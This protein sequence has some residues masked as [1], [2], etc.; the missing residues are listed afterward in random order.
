M[1]QFHWPGFDST[2]KLSAEEAVE[3]AARIAELSKAGLPLGPG[4]RAL[5]GELPGCRLPHVLR[6]MADRLDA[7][8]DLAA[9]IQAEGR[10]LP[11][12]LRGLV[13]AGIHSGRLSDVLEEYIDLQRSQWELRRRVWLSLAYPLVLLAAM[14]LLAILA[15]Y[16]VV[17]EF[18]KIF[19]DFQ[20]E[21]PKLTQ[22]VIS[23]AA[24]VALSLI[25]LLGLV[26]LIGLM[27]R[28]G[29]H[30]GWVWSI[31]NRVPMIGPLMR[32]KHL[33]QFSRLM[34]L[35]LEQQVPLP[36][37]LRLAAAGLRDARLAQGCAGVADDVARGRSLSESL[38]AR[39]QF[40]ASLIPMVQWGQ[41][42]PALAE[43][44]RAAGDMFEGRVR[45]Q[46]T[47]LEA[48]MLPIMLLVIVTFAGLFV[49]AMLSPLIS[50]ITRLSM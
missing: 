24:P 16:Y 42:A 34:G 11:P 22:L 44:F 27:F 43:A 17:R 29:P 38:A 6:A 25:I 2:R 48:V 5:A 35:L 31:L 49:I 23:G 50:L 18:K 39:R 45:A 28:I 30:V 13:L 3:L 36:D 41:Q 46:G 19:D 4:L 32:W 21:L 14:T 20:T 9:T 33:S 47:L 15:K 10:R 37:A 26:L 8:V 40:P 1:T 7:G 12:S